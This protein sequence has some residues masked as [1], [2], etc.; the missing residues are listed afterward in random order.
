MIIKNG[1]SISSG[2]FRTDGMVIIPCSMKTLASISM[3]L[4]IL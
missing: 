2:S 4:M 3:D 1:R